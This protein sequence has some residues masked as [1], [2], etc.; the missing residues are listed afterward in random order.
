MLALAD[1]LMRGW[2]VASRSKNDVRRGQYRRLNGECLSPPRGRED[3]YPS[4]YKVKMHKKKNFGIIHEKYKNY[5]LLLAFTKKICYNK[6]NFNAE[7]SPCSK[8]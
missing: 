8:S 7:V 2:W 3:S 4:I 6:T 1:V 5:T